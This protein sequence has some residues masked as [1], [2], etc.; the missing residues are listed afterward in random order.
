ML[1][2][3]II[4]FELR[5]LGS[6]V[7]YVIIQST[8]KTDYFHDKTK[9]FEPNYQ[10]NYYLLLKILQNATG[11]AFLTWAKLLTKFN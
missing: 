5:G 8:H 11:L 3:L 9:I 6:Q 2:E 4:E 10:V 7:V 1:T